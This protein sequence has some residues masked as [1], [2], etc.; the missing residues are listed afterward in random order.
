M[1]NCASPALASF[2]LPAT[3]FQH[4]QAAILPAEG[5]GAHGNFFIRISAQ[6]RGSYLYV[7]A[8]GYTPA[9]ELPMY[10]GAFRFYG[11][12]KLLQAGRQVLRKKLELGD[13]EVWPDDR[14]AA[15]GSVKICVPAGPQKGWS[16]EVEAGYEFNSGTG[17]VTPIPPT[18]KIAI[19][20][21]EPK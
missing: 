19:P 11:N 1:T 21:P 14:Y 2:S 12:V 20:F 4:S 10:R 8:R 13:Q 3:E 6:L 7:S 18:G 5:I 17:F 15:I 16:L 9:M